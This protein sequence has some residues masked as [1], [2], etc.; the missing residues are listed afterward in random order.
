MIKK[1]SLEDDSSMPM[2]PYW[3]PGLTQ[4]NLDENPFD[5]SV[6]I[7]LDTSKKIMSN[8]Q[9]EIQLQEGVWLWKYL[10]SKSTWQ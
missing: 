8:E 7:Q 1:T 6:K 2:L 3:P 10:F 9:R 4:A 5:I